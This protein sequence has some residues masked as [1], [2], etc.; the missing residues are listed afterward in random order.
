[1]KYYDVEQGILSCILTLRVCREVIIRV[2]YAGIYFAL[3]K[4]CAA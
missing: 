3:N 4:Q 1:M 2:Q